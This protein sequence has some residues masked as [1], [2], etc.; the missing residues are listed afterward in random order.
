MVLR[1][2]AELY[3]VEDITVS[4]YGVR[5]AICAEDPA[6]R[7]GVTVG[8]R[9]RPLY[10]SVR[11]CGQRDI[12]PTLCMAARSGFTQ[13]WLILMRDPGDHDIFEKREELPMMRRLLAGLLAGVA[14]LGLSA[15]G[16]GRAAAGAQTKR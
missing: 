3:G 6:L 11:R 8:G 5:G 4:H 13:P 10:P 1:F 2:L 7:A 12:L 9:A 16:A 15:C 14:V